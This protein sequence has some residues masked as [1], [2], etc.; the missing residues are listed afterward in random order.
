MHVVTERARR[1]C[2]CVCVKTER[3]HVGECASVAL[4]T[5]NISTVAEDENDNNK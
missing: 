4:P 1:V 3:T 5:G 2:V